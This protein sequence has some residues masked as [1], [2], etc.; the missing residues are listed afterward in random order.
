MTLSAHCGPL[1]VDRRPWEGSRLYQPG[2]HV[3]RRVRALNR[4][5]PSWVGVEGQT[6]LG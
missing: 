5:L 2:P 3:L 6:R 1:P 4:A